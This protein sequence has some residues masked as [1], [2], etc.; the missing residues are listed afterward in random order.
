MKKEITLKDYKDCLFTKK[1]KQRTMNT[2]R[3]RKHNI[4]TESI[5]K[6]AL[7]ADDDKRII[8]ENGIDTMAIG[9][10][11]SQLNSIFP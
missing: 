5:T 1:E 7:S 9:H 6:T 4:Y 8:L 3:S 2:F 11:K 10:W